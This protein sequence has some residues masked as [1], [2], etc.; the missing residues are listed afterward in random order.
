MTVP[1]PP[2]EPPAARSRALRAAR[3]P[4]RALAH[5]LLHPARPPAPL[6]GQARS[7]LLRRLPY[8]VALGLTASLLPSTAHLLVT[9]YGL[10][11]GL[12]TLLAIGQAAPLLLA[13]SRPLQAWWII[14]GTDVLGAA[15]LLTG[16]GD[17]EN[18]WPW[19]VPVI[20]GYLALML[21]LALREPRRTLVTV[22][23]LT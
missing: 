20:L 23:V 6:L 13:V 8:L 16:P 1:S 9:D 3:R 10:G 11:S 22:W 4:I 21:P 12:A 2:A 5:G 7:R 17:P 14:F 18:P 19:T 15:T